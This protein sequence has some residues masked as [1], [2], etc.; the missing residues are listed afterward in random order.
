M[1]RHVVPIEAVK[2]DITTEL[3]DAIVNAAGGS[4][5]SGG[6]GVDGAIHRAAGPPLLAECRHFSTRNPPMAFR[7][8][9][10]WPPEPGTSGEMGDPHRRPESS[11]GTDGSSSAGVL[12]RDL[13]QGAVKVGARSVA[14]PRSARVSMVRKQ[15]TSPVSRSPR[16]GVHPTWASWTWCALSCPVQPPTRRSSPR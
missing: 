10:P 11:C 9:K 4:L 12:L 16:S 13:A 3:V 6:G 2:G 15:P 7:S 1:A 5:L 8:E 14:F